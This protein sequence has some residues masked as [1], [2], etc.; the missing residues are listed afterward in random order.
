MASSSINTNCMKYSDTLNAAKSKE[1][2][3]EETS[4]T[5]CRG[6]DAHAPTDTDYNMQAGVEF[7]EAVDGLLAAGRPS[8]RG[9]HC[10][11]RDGRPPLHRG[12]A[13]VGSGRRG[14]ALCCGGGVAPGEGEAVGRARRRHR[15][16]PGV[17]LDAEGG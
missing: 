9:G 10:A 1:G 5:R 6:W 7:E 4:P 17:K 3:E 16:P 11:D 12:G 15:G 14:G 8:P 2:K 13:L